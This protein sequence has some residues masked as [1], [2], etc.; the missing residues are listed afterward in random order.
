MNQ[1]EKQRPPMAGFHHFGATVTDVEASAAWYQKV[2]GL[3]RIP[4]KF[5]HYGNEET[6]YTVLLTD[7]SC[8]IV[9]GVHHNK[10]NDGQPFDETRTGLDHISISVP[11]RSD[12]ESWAKWLDS[13]AVAHSGVTDIDNVIKYSALVFRDPDNIQLKL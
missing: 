3:E 9:I 13:L 12:L 8:G 1:T 11:S 2:L 10:G 5:P 7:L 6:G 4:A